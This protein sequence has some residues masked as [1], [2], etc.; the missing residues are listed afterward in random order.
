MRPADNIKRFIDKAAVSTRPPADQAVLEAVLAAQKKATDKISAASRPS[1]RSIVMRSPITTLAAAAVVVAA[2]VL[3]I[4]LWDKSAPAA[5]ALEMTIQANQSVRWLHIKSFTVGHAEP[6]EGWI[7]F[8]AD[9][10]A[11]RARSQMPD[12]ASP[13]EGAWVLA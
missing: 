3:F 8:G 4:G 6:Q 9:G 7:E 11:R 5:Y 13:M 12:W 2:V 10:Q 1:L